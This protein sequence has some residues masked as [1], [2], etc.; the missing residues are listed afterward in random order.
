MSRW[1]IPARCALA[2]P[3]RI[4]FG[5][6]DDAVDAQAPSRDDVGERLAVDVRHGDV[7][8][9]LVLTDL[10]HGDDVRV[11]E[12]R[13]RLRLAFEAGERIG[14]RRH[15]VGEKLERRFP[16]ELAVLGEIDLTHSALAEL[17]QD[18]VL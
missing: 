18:P 12:P 4:C 1:T 16:V 10:V 2:R 5:D 14:V 15:L 7:R 13:G 17:A 11:V 6:F 3:S 9:A 8:A